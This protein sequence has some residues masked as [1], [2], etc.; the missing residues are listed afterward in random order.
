LNVIQLTSINKFHLQ[1][2][3][4]NQKNHKS[5]TGGLILPGL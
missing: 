1:V 2:P 5:V 3:D 4:L